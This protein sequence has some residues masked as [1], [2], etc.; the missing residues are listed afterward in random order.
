MLEPIR[1]YARE[2]LEASGERQVVGVRHLAWVRALSA[3]LGRGFFVDQRAASGRASLEHANICHALDFALS[4][5]RVHDATRVIA[6]M[7]Y[8]WTLTGQPDGR[9]W[10]DRTLA[11]CPR[12]TPARVRGDAVFAA[13]M[14]AVNEGDERRSVP[15]LREALRCYEAS[16]RPVSH[17]WALTWF[18]RAGRAGTGEVDGRT[19]EEWFTQALEEFTAVSDV[20]GTGWSLTLLARCALR[21]DQLDLAHERARSALEIAETHGIDQV[22]AAARR[23]LAVIAHARGDTGQADELIARAASGH[24]DTGDRWHHAIAL[25][26]AA[27][28][29]TGRHDLDRAAGSLLEAMD[30]VA[31]LPE[32]EAMVNVLVAAFDF[33]VHVGRAAEVAPIVAGLAAEDYTLLERVALIQDPEH[34]RD[35]FATMRTHPTGRHS[36]RR[37]V[38][39]TSEI[40][41]RWSEEP[42]R[43]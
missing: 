22:A 1:Q 10:V 30:L 16:S 14:F 27:G 17:A 43:V 29:A 23:W 24:E 21:A 25:A 26:T 18:G 15:L 37:A 20:A 8:P 31:E 19:P 7:A 40:M 13:A 35:G 4:A 36:L 6:A 39:M 41:A 9:R 5:G 3:E 42:A 33:L 11:A 32:D 34:L 12:N 38:T 28:I 2:R